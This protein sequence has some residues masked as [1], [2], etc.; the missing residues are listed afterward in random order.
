MVTA[1]KSGFINYDGW[2]ASAKHN[3][4]FTLEKY[5]KYFKLAFVEYW[6]ALF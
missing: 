2:E 6:N 4:Q 3:L 1:S 5:G